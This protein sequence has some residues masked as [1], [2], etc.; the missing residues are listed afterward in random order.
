ME[1][2]LEKHN[3]K[4]KWYQL[5]KRRIFTN[6]VCHKAA[7]VGVECKVNHY[8]KVTRNTF[9]SD[10]V[11]FNGMKITGKGKVSIGRYFHSGSECLMIT[12]THNYE[13]EMIPYDDTDISRSIEIDDFVWLGSR[14]IVL[15]GVHI[16]EGAIIQAGSVVVNDI[17]A[18][19]I[20]GGAPAK[21]FKY[22]DKE[23]FM[24]LKAK[25]MYF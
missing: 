24:N 17:P 7:S 8:S 14:V 9:L 2:K 1:K 22:R 11:S 10:H 5:L 15:G 12:D 19:A 23:H 20:A 3:T 4:K 6:Y 18:Y 16:G 25:E 13:G 21:V